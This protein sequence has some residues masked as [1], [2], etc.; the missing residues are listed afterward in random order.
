[1]KSQDKTLQDQDKTR[2][3]KTKTRQDKT[4]DMYGYRQT[5]THIPIVAVGFPYDDCTT[6]TTQGRIRH[7]MTRQ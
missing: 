3:D 2:Q 7:D 4:S 6:T 5:H 1:M